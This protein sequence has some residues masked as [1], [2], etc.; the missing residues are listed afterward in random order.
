MARVTL[1]SGL[2][3]EELAEGQGA[4]AEWGKI[5]SIRYSG[6]LEDGTPFDSSLSHDVP[7]VFP[8]GGGYVM[9]GL[10]EGVK[11]MRV[12]GARRLTIPPGLT[13]AAA[14]GDAAVPEGVTL[15]YEIELLEIL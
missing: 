9:D 7:F 14:G 6:W 12:G 2:S 8:I 4:V 13:R 5:V 1:E 15:V 11:G 3:Y 10:E